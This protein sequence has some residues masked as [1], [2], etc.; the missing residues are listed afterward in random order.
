MRHLLTRD[1]GDNQWLMR[2][3]EKHLLVLLELTVLS[4]NRKNL[5]ISSHYFNID[6]F[7][8]IDIIQKWIMQTREMQRYPQ[9]AEQEQPEYKYP[10]A[11]WM[12]F[13]YSR[14]LI[15]W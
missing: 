3:L 15:L 5:L 13:S 8:Y 9:A 4:K 1:A 7:Q 14:W 11:A 12:K 2:S 10:T 6:A